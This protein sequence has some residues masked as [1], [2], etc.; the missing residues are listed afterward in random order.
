[1]AYLSN[2][3]PDPPNG[4][5]VIDVPGDKDV[6]LT[7]IGLDISGAVDDLSDPASGGGA[8]GAGIL[9]E[10]GNG[11]LVVENCNIHNNEDGIL[12]GGADAASTNG[13]TVTI[14]G[15]EIDNNGLPSTSSRFGYDHDIYIGAV[16]QFTITDSY[17]HDALGGHEIKSRAL[18]STIEN[19]VIAD[20]SAPA[21]YEI[22]LPNGGTDIVTGNVI[23]KGPNSPQEHMVAFGEEGALAG[24]S[25]VLSDNTFI[26]AETSRGAI[27]LFNEAGV[28]ATIA[29]DTFYGAISVSSSSSDVATGATYLPLSEAPAYQSETP[30]CFLA[31]TRIQTDRGE[32]PVERLAIGDNAITL[33]GLAR[34]IAWI[35][36][37]RV[38]STRFRRTAASPVILRKGALADN[39]P[40]AELRIT[41]AHGLYVDGVLIPVEFLVNHRSILWDDRAQEVTL[42]HIE[43]ETHDVL[44]ANGAPAESYRDDGNRW[45]FQNAASAPLAAAQAP[46]VPVLT[47]GAVVD[48]AWRRFLDRAGPRPHRVLTDDPDLHLIA[49]GVRVD[50]VRR[51]GGRFTFRLASAA[52]PVRL[53]SRA[54]SPQELGLARDPRVLGVGIQALSLVQGGRRHVIEAG[55]ARLIEGFHAFEAEA[56]LRWTTG[57]A[58]LPPEVFGGA[59]GAVDL[60]VQLGG[61]TQYLDGEVAR[62]RRAA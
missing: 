54:A 60:I 61:A 24:S 1:V 4:R 25:L 3:Q 11:A 49:D 41:R 5:A 59:L 33:G 55:D 32:V 12:T 18:A 30:L 34:P 39:V 16:N 53:V 14:T 35:G 44:I 56:G 27:G 2:P 47:G 45:L 9:F 21:S 8:N 10:T 23:E 46:C 17:I 7:L 13:M 40:N 58:V 31:G 6:N 57:D 51:R 20:G 62:E 42:F 15:S 52:A 26:N 22:D 37:G 28:S 19:N 29:D 43:L 38:L 50:A 36:K 48:A